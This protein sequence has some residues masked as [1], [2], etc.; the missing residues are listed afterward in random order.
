MLEYQFAGNE[1]WRILLF[2]GV[3]LVCLVAGRA[4]RFLLERGAGR[5]EGDAHSWRPILL[6]AVG[7]ALGLVALAL[8]FRLGLGA[9]VLAENLAEMARTLSGILNAA[10]AGYAIYALVDVVDHQ[11]LRLSARTQSRMDDVLAPMVGKTIRITVG[12]LVI[13]NVIKEISGKSITTILA[14]L[15]VGGLAV[16]L[17]GQDTIKN[18]F[19]SLV[20]LGDR[21]FEIG[22]RVVVGGHDGPVESVGFRSTRIR[23]L[24]GHLVTVPNGELVNQTIENIGKRPHIRRLM[25]I[26]ITY[27]TPPEKVRRA[28]EIVKEVLA[29]HEGMRPDFPPRVYFSEFMDCALNLLAIYW[30]HPADYWAYMAFSERVNMQILE[31]FNAEGI[32]FAFPTQTLYLKGDSAESGGGVSGAIAG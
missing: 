10:A 28:L 7:R 24:T 11:L 17:A 8:G 14:G 5:M 32:E 21:P 3:L 2:F 16:A 6:R 18:F 20:I 29:D 19:G 26:S 1:V 4:A 22:D 30:Y 15:G 25:N 31:R 13:I 23:T 27:D 12:V 9:L